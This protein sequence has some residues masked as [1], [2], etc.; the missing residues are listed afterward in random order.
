MTTLLKPWL[1]VLTVLGVLGLGAAAQATPITYDFSGTLA[2][3]LAGDTVKGSFTIDPAA[4]T[5]GTWS[6]TGPGGD[7]LT[8][9]S[10]L[11]RHVVESGTST[12]FEELFFVAGS[13]DSLDLFFETGPLPS[14]DPSTFYIASFPISGGN[15]QSKFVCSNC[16]AG[17]AIAVFSSGSVTP[18]APAAVP[19][20]TTLVLLGT[21]LIGAGVRRY[22]RRSR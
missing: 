6:F 22:R 18:A 9:S 16:V 5:L 10:A 8:G 21:G 1:G 7:S 4:A 13:G 19:E 15:D 11:I 12:G 2:G 14:F 20:P 17:R 3:Q